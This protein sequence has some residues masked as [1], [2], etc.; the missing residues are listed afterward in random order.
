[1]HPA[2]FSSPLA[3]YNFNG[4]IISS[5]NCKRGSRC[6]DVHT[7]RHHYQLRCC[8]NIECA[9]VVGQTSI[10]AKTASSSRRT[11]LPNVKSPIAPGY[12]TETLKTLALSLNSAELTTL[13]E[14][15]TAPKSRPKRPKKPLEPY[16]GTSRGLLTYST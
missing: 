9:L 12:A 13:P 2:P 5:T 4:L 10:P 15:K 3:R 1:M 16:L 7:V 11:I 14:A 6:G 8:K